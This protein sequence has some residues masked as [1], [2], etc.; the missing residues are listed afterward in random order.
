MNLINR[1]MS[2]L[3]LPA[4]LLGP[5]GCQTM[6]DHKIASGTAI[7]A[8]TGALAGGI[9][10]NQSGNKWEGALIGAAAGAAIGGGIGWY[11]DRQAKKLQ[12]IEGVERV[13]RVSADVPPPSY[14]YE[15]DAGVSEP[16]PEVPRVEHLRFSMR[17]D[18]LFERGQATIT[19]G[20]M[21][22]LDE[23]AQALNDTQDTMVIVTGYASS[24]G[25][26]DAN[27]RLSE[28]RANSVKNYLISRRIDPSR[29][30][31]IGLGES[32]PIGDN[33]TESGR[34]MNRRV[35]IEVYP[36]DENPGQ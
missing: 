35:E 11:L 32:N 10:G 12:A 22:T 33:N 31:A 26:E 16:I 5:I 28:N 23:V 21:R 1:T 29:I 14:D 8:A 30:R 6:S 17:S 15:S 25:A 7:G 19:S 36:L 2:A 20:G 18:M 3:L 34:A 27:L 13:E 4:L 24:E 9:I